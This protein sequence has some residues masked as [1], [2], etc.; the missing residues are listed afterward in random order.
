[1][2]LVTI[3]ALCLC[4]QLT[5]YSQEPTHP[6]TTDYRIVKTD[7][8]ELIGRILKEDERELTIRSS[9]GRVIVVPQ[10][11]IREIKAVRTEELSEKGVFIGE[12]RFATRYFITTNGLPLKKGE[13]Y[14]QWNLFGPDFQFAVSNRVGLGIMTTWLA[15]PIIGTAKFSIPLKKDFQ[16]ALGTMVGTSSWITLLGSDKNAGGALP[17]ASLSYGNRRANIA[18]SG[19]YGVIWAEGDSDGRAL[20]SI[21]GMIKVSSRISLVFDS[22]IV[23]KGKTKRS[24]RSEWQSVYDPNT[25]IY[26]D[27]LVTITTEDRKPGLGLF[28]PG[29]RW[30]QAEGKA[31]QFGFTGISFDGE[32]LPIPM[33]MVQWYRTL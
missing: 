32:L 29:V 22:F 9:D 15:I 14:I 33:P 1:M 5:G 6:D 26:H 8:S 3:F 20:T 12:D 25:G 4:F 17:F 30:H 16:V 28:I 24:T 27:Q 13:H 10:Y 23:I 18:A 11:V 31:F 7:G 21:A 19:G 2:R